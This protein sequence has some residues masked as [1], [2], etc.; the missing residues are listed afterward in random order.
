M[1]I[2]SDVLIAAQ[3]ADKAYGIP[4]SISLAQWAI[5]SGWGKHDLGVHNYFGMKAPCGK[6]GKPLVP[7]V[8]LRTREQDRHGHNYYIDAPFRK[9]ES[10]EEAF[11]EHAKLLL[12]PI[13][14]KARMVL[15]D[16]DKFAD[17][18]TGLY[19]TDLGYG[20]ALKAVMHGGNFYQYD[21]RRN[22]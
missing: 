15:P 1:K 21:Q 10:V 11:D 5:E 3:K 16:V 14:A 19:A 13:Y 4:A 12:R 8:M 6:D 20:K 18:L 9:F 17:A 7:F 22:V 2:P